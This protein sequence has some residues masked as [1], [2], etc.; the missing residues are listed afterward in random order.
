LARGRGRGGSV[1]L[2]Q[3][4]AGTPEERP[5]ARIPPAPQPAQREAALYEPTARVLADAWG[6]DR[7][8]N[9]WRV[10]Q[11]A[12]QGRRETGG[13]WSRPDLAVISLNK[14]QYL[15]GLSLEV[16]TFEVKTLEG[17][18]VTAVYEALAH[19][20]S[21]TRAYVL[22]KVRE[23]MTGDESSRL[24]AVQ[25]EAARHGIGLI[26]M[27]EAD[28]FTTWE[29]IVEPSRLDA[30]PERLND[31]ISTQFSIDNRSALQLELR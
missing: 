30:A 28:D 26:T 5:R 15:P 31:F 8:F 9:W 4:E 1:R 29:E 22:V 2:V 3:A 16:W 25:E 17:L 11:T 12:L 14:F 20:R 7:R 21:A 27:L 10:E 19:G 24:E 23:K 13:R 6:K 18:D